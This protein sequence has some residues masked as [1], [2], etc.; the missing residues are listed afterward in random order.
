[1]SFIVKVLRRV[2]TVCTL[3]YCS[4]SFYCLLQPFPKSNVQLRLYYLQIILQQIESLIIY[5][6]HFAVT[7]SALS[8]HIERSTNGIRQGRLFS[9]FHCNY[10]SHIFT[11]AFFV[12][13]AVYQIV[14]E[15]PLE[16]G[17]LPGPTKAHSLV[18][19][20]Y[21]LMCQLISALLIMSRHTYVS[22]YRQ[23]RVRQPV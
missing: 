17:R 2:E 23:M 15:L 11:S 21:I 8:C 16:N 18:F 4:E 6:S 1:M 7:C 9:F 14:C 12:R 20:F 3:N 10:I 19:F 22:V 5:L 13:A